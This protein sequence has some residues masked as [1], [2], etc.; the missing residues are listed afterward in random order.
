MKKPHPRRKEVLLMTRRWFFAATRIGLVFMAVMFFG[1]QSASGATLLSE[2][3]SSSTTIT[4]AG[5]N[6][7]SGST[8]DDNLN[9]WLGFKWF[10]ANSGGDYFAQHPVLTGDE[11]NLMFRGLS[12]AGIAA[13]TSLT[14]DFDFATEGSRDGRV[15]VAG[16]NNGLHNL[17]PNAPWFESGSDDGVVL[18]NEGLEG[19]KSWT[20]AHFA[21]TVP[22]TYDVLVVGFVMGGTSGFRAVDSIN[23]ASAAVPEPSTLLLLGSGLLGLALTGARK[24]R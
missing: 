6:L 2:E 9:T 19:G 5:I 8:S 7:I 12:A 17:E 16:L 15:Y 11:T 10:I 18:L 23:L 21:F 3:F 24:K 20:P 4:G 1:M 14:L 13:G 22:V